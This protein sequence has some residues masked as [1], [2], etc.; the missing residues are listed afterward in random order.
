MPVSPHIR[1]DVPTQRLD[2][3]SDG[4]EIVASYPVSTSR[5]GLGFEEG[6]F[7][8]PTG[9]FQIGEKIGGGEPERMVFKERIP[10]GE[11][12]ETGGEED[13]VL[14]RILW[15][16]G[17]DRENDNTRERYIYLHGTNQEDFIGTPASHGCI[18]LRN[19]DIVDLFDRVEV[20]TSVQIRP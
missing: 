17:L 1:V 20:G 14:T 6:S 11:V 19:S 16:K 10:T 5:Y 3:L 13:L 15:L 8:T 7:K 18:R 12:T 4:G 9:N 2:L